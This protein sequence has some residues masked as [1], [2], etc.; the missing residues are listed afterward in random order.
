MRLLAGFA[1][2]AAAGLAATLRV[3]VNDASTSDDRGEGDTLVIGIDPIA[4]GIRVWIVDYRGG[5]R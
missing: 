5:R 3:T 2:G 1:L 4:W